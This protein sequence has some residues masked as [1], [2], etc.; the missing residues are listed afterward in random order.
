MQGGWR[1]GG[2]IKIVF[3]VSGEKYMCAEAGGVVIICGGSAVALA[4]VLKSIQFSMHHDDIMY[5][6]YSSNIV[7]AAA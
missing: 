3:F 6:S 5:I 2:A 4:F 1:V 7:A